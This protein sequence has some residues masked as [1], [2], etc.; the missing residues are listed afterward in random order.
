M[1]S[2][3]LTPATN[4]PGISLAN[5]SGGTLN[6][7]ERKNKDSWKLIVVYRGLHCPICANYLEKLH[8]LKN[9]LAELNVEAVA[10]SAD[11][12]EKVKKQFEDYE[13]SFSVGYDLTIEQ[14]EAL[15]LYISSPRSPQET[16]RVFAEPGMFI[17]NENDE[18]H[19]IDIS[20]A[21]FSRPDL[22]GVVDGIKFIRN[23]EN[24]YPIRGTYN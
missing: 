5:F 24:K 16:D 18:L 19:I 22:D 14:M 13:P 15:G 10:I 6:L 1:S 20:N 12:L 11:P 23:P 2:T 4:I 17:L 3:K 7:S 21:P 9:K 8:N